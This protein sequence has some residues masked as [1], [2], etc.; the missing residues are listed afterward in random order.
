MKSNSDLLR[1]DGPEIVN[2]R[3][4]IVRLRGFF[5]GGWVCLENF[6]LGYPGHATGC[7][8]RWPACWA[9]PKPSFFSSV[10]CTTFSLKMICVSSR[11]WE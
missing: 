10:S 11:A 9:K 1:V 5:L 2:G 7:V 8:R 4:E 6:M 3:G